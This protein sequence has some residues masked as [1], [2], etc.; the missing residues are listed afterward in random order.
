LTGA[1]FFF[2]AGFS[3][4]EDES[5]SEGAGLAAAFPF[6]CC[7]TSFTDSSE[8]PESLPSE[9]ESESSLAFFFGTTAFSATFLALVALPLLLALALDSARSLFWMTFLGGASS[10]ELSSSS[11]SDELSFLAFFFFSACSLAR[12][13][14]FSSSF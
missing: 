12:A 8:E 2:G 7:L 11:E 13:A 10:E 4:S 5:L 3:L 1:A 6:F 9:L 14:F